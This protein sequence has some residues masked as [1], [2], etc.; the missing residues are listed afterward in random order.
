MF[1]G[2]GKAKT[3]D[4]FSKV[5][6]E[7][8]RSLAPKTDTS[9]ERAIIAT[10]VE[11][12][13]KADTT[14][15]LK[16]VEHLKGIT[17]EDFSEEY[18]KIYKL[19]LQYLSEVPN[20]NEFTLREFLDGN[21]PKEDINWLIYDL[22]E[23]ATPLDAL[24][25]AVETIRKQSLIA[26][27]TT[28]ILKALSETKDPQKLLSKLKEIEEEIEKKATTEPPKESLR[29]KILSLRTPKD[30]FLNRKERE[31]VIPEFIP[32]K[33]LI[34]ISAKPS[35]GKS[36]LMLML[37]KKYFIPAGYKV[38]L[39]DMDNLADTLGER[40]HKVGLIDELD[41]DLFV[42]TRETADI[43]ANSNDWKLIKEWLLNEDEHYVVILDTLKDF[44][45]GYDLN[46]DTDAGI[47]MEELKALASKHTV[48]FLH[49][50]RKQED[51]D[52]PYKNSTTINEKCEVFYHL[53]KDPQTGV[54]K[55]RAFKDRIRVKPLI[56]F[57]IVEKKDGSLDLELVKDP[58]IKELQAFVKAVYKAIEEGFETKRKISTYVADNTDIGKH[59]A[60]EL[61]QKYTG[62]L[63]ATVKGERNS[64]IYKPLMPLEKALRK[65]EEWLTREQ[66]EN[67]KLPRDGK[68]LENS[69]SESLDFQ[70]LPSGQNGGQ[71]KTLEN[72]ELPS[73]PDI[74]IKGENWAAEKESIKEAI[75]KLLDDGVDIDLEVKKV[76]RA[77]ERTV[78][79]IAKDPTL[80]SLLLELY[81]ANEKGDVNGWEYLI[82]EVKEGKRTFKEAIETFEELSGID[83]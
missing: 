78:E 53:K 79:E 61:L 4:Y 15:I 24:P 62:Y 42:F 49:H 64:I 51:E 66:L 77:D 17:P 33:T 26:K 83:F 32:K 56:E 35:S 3:K 13:V 48:I 68:T 12:I 41:Q 14:S 10:L 34:G 50:V 27:T 40:L 60:E 45:T 43:K 72:Q 36:L 28:E 54:L 18:R 11:F 39:L 38:V 22:I 67:Q 46:S 69:D 52:N 59:R 30:A 55:L 58:R 76:H 70:E 65:V 31:Y 20:W 81:I 9:A 37:I 75:Q 29:E 25:S 8:L 71:V 2:N 19:L 7:V 82:E 23:E 57:E 21:L 73:C 6:E 16:A 74:Y 80:K 5:R 47:V 63:W 1:N 44:A